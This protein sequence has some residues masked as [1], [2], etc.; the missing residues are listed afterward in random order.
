MI[1]IIWPGGRRGSWDHGM[2][3]E[4]ETGELWPTVTLENAGDV[5]ETGAIVVA[6]SWLGDRL[7]EF[8]AQL[9]RMPW[10]VVVCVSDERAM[11]DADLFRG[12]RR[13]VWV[14]SP[15]PGKTGDRHFLIGPPWRTGETVALI[16]IPPTPL[17]DRPLRWS[18]SGQ[19]NHANRIACLDAFAEVAHGSAIISGGF[20]QGLPRREHLQ[21]LT[22]TAIAPCP[23]G[24]HI[25]DTFRLYEA[26]EAGCLPIADRRA[27][28]W[29]EGPGY[30]EFILGA[31]PFPCV[32]SWKDELP[33]LILRFADPLAL[34]R[35]ANKAG[36]WWQG[37][38]RRVACALEEDALT[39]GASPTARNPV[40]VIMSASWIPSHPSTEIIEEAILR[41]RA[42]PELADAEILV[43]IDGLHPDYAAHA[44][45]YEE[46]KR[47]F[48]DLCAHD[49]RFAGVLPMVFD[50]HLHQAATTRIA[51]EEV[52]TPLMLYVEHDTYPMGPIDWPG[53]IRA[54]A[55][56]AVNMVKLSIF[57]EVI[58]EHRDL[59]PDGTTPKD[60]AGVP[61]L[62]SIQYSTRPHLARTEWYREIARQFFGRETRTYVEWILHTAMGE[63]IR[64]GVD[65]WERWGV[66]LYAPREGGL[67]RSGT[68]NGRREVS[69]TSHKIV[70]DGAPPEGAPQ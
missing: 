39:V 68:S 21:R 36:A 12:D 24:V 46:W 16:Q 52:R 11:I 49:V 19:V 47:R 1:P 69:M 50:E 51:L 37:Y 63:R 66:W 38:R 40:T 60:V 56:P 53:I 4:A 27:P 54:L 33:G 30:W 59:Y 26:I 34:Q 65:T 64:R 28:Y 31:E 57:D 10:A 13:I 29:P 58:P 7:E 20:S 17:V 15:N 23:S 55:E 2:L 48:I 70:Y 35:A 41:T 32:D 62:R 8:R 22:R 3:M 18:F 61:L 5:L 6:S 14:Q 45:D 25:P 9:A 43:T 42:Y 67:L 44:A